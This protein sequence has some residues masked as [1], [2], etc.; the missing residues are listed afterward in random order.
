VQNHLPDESGFVCDFLEPARFLGG[1]NASSKFRAYFTCYH[2]GFLFMLLSSLL[3]IIIIIII[4]FIPVWEC[5]DNLGR[6]PCYW[7]GLTKA[8]VRSVYW[9]RNEVWSVFPYEVIYDIA[10][11]IGF[12]AHAI[13]YWEL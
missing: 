13:F 3:F 8:R 5:K 12:A 7:I 6:E 11:E 2:R 10:D 1:G 9:F 4:F